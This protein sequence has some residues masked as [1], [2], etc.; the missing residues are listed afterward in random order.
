MIQI[1][2]DLEEDTTGPVFTASCWHFYVAGP[3]TCQKQIDYK[4][5]ELTPTSSKLGKLG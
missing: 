1:K 2:L 4:E 3:S 5:E